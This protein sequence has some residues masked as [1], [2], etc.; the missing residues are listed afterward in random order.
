MKMLGS[1]ILLFLTKSSICICLI[2]RIVYASIQCFGEYFLLHL[3]TLFHCPKVFSSR[4]HLS[5]LLW[6]FSIRKLVQSH[7]HMQISLPLRNHHTHIATDWTPNFVK[8]FNVSCIVY[9]PLILL[10]VVECVVCCACR[11]VSSSV[12][13]MRVYCVPCMVTSCDNWQSHYN[14]QSNHW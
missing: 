10:Q 3:N 1:A 2:A 6:Y 9:P 11:Q 12:S 4:Q 14:W 8:K 5:R 7:F 13:R